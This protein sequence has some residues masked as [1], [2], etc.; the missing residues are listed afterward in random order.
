MRINSSDSKALPPNVNVFNYFATLHCMTEVIFSPGPAPA[1]LA[2]VTC[3]V[4]KS[5]TSARAATSSQFPHLTLHNTRDLSL[6]QFLTEAGP[7]NT[8]I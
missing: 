4:Q 3:Y 8:M 7:H 5:V 2:L 1:P 6:R